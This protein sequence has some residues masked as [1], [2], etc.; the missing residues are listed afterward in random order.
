M[1]L[2]PESSE[3]EC[4]KPEGHVAPRPPVAGSVASAGTKKAG[5]P[6]AP[7]A[8]RTD[9]AYLVTAVSAFTWP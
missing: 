5:G 8:L 9:W 6:E 7:P 2:P 1:G 3:A 4:P